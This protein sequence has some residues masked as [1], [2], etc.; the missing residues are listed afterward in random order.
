MIKKEK[1]KSNKKICK[2]ITKYNEPCKYEA[3]LSGYC[4][5]HFKKNV[6]EEKKN[7]IPDF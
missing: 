6:Y 4:L 1:K 2:G 7:V 3:V 5:I